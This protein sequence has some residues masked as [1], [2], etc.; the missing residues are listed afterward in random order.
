M[1]GGSKRDGIFSRL[2]FI[3]ILK[4]GT[5]AGQN[6][7]VEKNKKG[8]Q[9]IENPQTLVFIMV[10]E[11]GIEPR[12]PCERGILSPIFPLSFKIILLP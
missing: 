9:S 12:C 10:P 5:I 11:L 7:N 6:G 3:E 1:F 2:F 8:L 4:S